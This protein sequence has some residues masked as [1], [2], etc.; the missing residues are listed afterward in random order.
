MSEPLGPPATGSDAAI[1]AAEFIIWQYATVKRI[2][3]QFPDNPE[4]KEAQR[5]WIDELRAYIDLQGG[6]RTLIDCFSSLAEDCERL[7]MVLLA[8]I[9]KEAVTSEA[10]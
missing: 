6:N 1:R 8:R 5:I 3:A 2:K 10:H 7:V 9:L 4:C